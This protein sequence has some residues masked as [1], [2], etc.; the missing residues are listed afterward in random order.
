[1]T[2]ALIYIVEDDGDVRASL[3][4]ALEASGYAVRAFCSAEA[5]LASDAPRDIDCIVSDYNLPGMS[6]LDMIEKLRST[7]SKSPAI[8]VSANAKTFVARAARANVVAVL[9]KP[10][11]YEA[12]TQ[13]LELIYGQR[14]TH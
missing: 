4:V 11:A 10:A 1:M 13:W 3:Q 5:L 12:L 6:G 8:I 14:D 2:N 9:R 7:G